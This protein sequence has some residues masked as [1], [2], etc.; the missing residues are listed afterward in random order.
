MIN[1]LFD[2]IFYINLNKDVERNDYMINQFKEFGITNYERFEA[3]ECTEVPD[4]SLWRNF[5]KQD[6]KYVKGSVGCRESHV[7][8]LKLAK[9]RDYKF[10]MI[11]EDD[12]K[13][14]T[15]LNGILKENNFQIGMS[16]MIYFGG[17]LERHFRGQVVGAYAYAVRNTLFE[18]VIHMAIPSG[19]EIDNFYAKI[20]QHMSYNNN[21]T[22]RYNAF[23]LR[24]ANTIIVN[25]TFN[26]NIR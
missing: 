11:L 14:L 5:N 22:G 2:K 20:I 19:M 12:V 17:L 3:I 15:N 8:I 18:D 6:E 24:P 4:K 26:S 9:E 10:V 21:T 16:D 1:T 23:M 13:I 7:G 25:Q